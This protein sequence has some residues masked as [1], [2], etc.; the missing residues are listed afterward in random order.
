MS[1]LPEIS[2][3]RIFYLDQLRVLAMI[4]VIFIHVSG[5]FVLSLKPES[6]GFF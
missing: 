6:Y 2:P 4:G 3:K 5:S 1:L